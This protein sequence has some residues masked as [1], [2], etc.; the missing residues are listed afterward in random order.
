MGDY[1]IS[2]RGGGGESEI[3]RESEVS[4]AGNAAKERHRCSNKLARY[5][6]EGFEIETGAYEARRKKK[7]Y[8]PVRLRRAKASGH[9][10]GGA[11]LHASYAD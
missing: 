2:R 11:R 4:R 6:Y 8:T 7:E 1:D 3:E 5:L 10:P 9:L